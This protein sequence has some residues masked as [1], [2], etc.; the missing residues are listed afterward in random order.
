M[1][2]KA[3]PRAGNNKTSSKVIRREGNIPA[4]LYAQGKE[5]ENIAVGAIEFKKILNKIVPG[6]LSTTIFHLDLGGK[7]R[8]AVLKEIQYNITT[9]DV[10]HLDFIEL[11]DNVPVE[12]KVPIQCTNVMDCVG[13]KLG[14]SV[15]QVV[16]T[17]KVRCLPKDIPAAFEVDVRDMN[18]GQEKKLSEIAMPHGVQPLMDTNTVAVAIA[19]K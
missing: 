16:R 1:E 6:T 14:G 13:V 15:R 5:G 8:K 4:I 3:S 18:V 7:K 11:I 2:L 17:V 12:L 10:S 19:K 9:Y